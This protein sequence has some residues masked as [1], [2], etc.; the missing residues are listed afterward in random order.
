MTHEQRRQRVRFDW[1]QVPDEMV[2]TRSL[3][4]SQLLSAATGKRVS[5]GDALLLV[6]NLWTWVVS[7]VREDAVDLA[8]EFERCSVLPRLKAEALLPT[9]LGWPGRHASVLIDA[10]LDTHVRVLSAEGD[11]VRVVDI[12]ERYARLAKKQNESKGRAKASVLARE[13]GWEPGP[14]STW[15]NSTT[16]ETVEGWRELVQLLEGGA[17]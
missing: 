11:C 5:H 12:R 10:L 8:G 14:K 7:Q 17:K 2:R 15:V 13:H 6:C 4:L 9:A 3:T 1:L 16:G